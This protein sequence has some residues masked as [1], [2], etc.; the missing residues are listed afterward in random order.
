MKTWVA[1]LKIFYYRLAAVAS[2]G[3]QDFDRM[4]DYVKVRL[5]FHF[6]TQFLI[7]SSIFSAFL[8]TLKTV[9][10]IELFSLFTMAN[11]RTVRN[12]LIKRDFCL[13]RNSLL[14]LGRVM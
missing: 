1:I 2:W 13:I 8:K 5:S 10:S 11:L 14:W 6:K 4:A 9:P 7:G 3:L 12:L